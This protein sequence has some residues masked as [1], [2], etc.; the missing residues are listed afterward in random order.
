MEPSASFSFKK[1]P[2]S[3]SSSSSLLLTTIIPVAM[4][5]L[6]S[7][8]LFSTSTHHHHSSTPP[9][10]ILQP[11]P[12]P[13]PHSFI[14]S[15]CDTTLYP[16]LCFNTISSI[17]IN[18][19]HDNHTK[20]RNVLKFYIQ[21]TINRLAITR[22]RMAAMNLKVREKNWV[23]NCLELLDLSQYELQESMNHLSPPYDDPPPYA[24]IKNLLSAAMTNE[25]TCIEGFADLK[26]N[27]PSQ[28]RFGRLFQK[29]LT[30]IMRMISNCLAITNYLETIGSIYT[31][32]DS[33]LMSKGVYR[34][35]VPSWMTAADRRLM[36]TSSRI[37]PPTV[38]VARDG[39]GNFTTIAAA[40]AAAPSRGKGRHVIQIKAGIY[41]ENLVIPRNKANIMLVG[42]GMNSTIITSNKNFVDGYT[43]FT[44]ATLTVV[45]NNFLARDLTI[46]NTSGP[47]KHQAVALRVTS[48]AAFYHCQF[49]SHQD[50]LYA[51]SLSQ[52]YREC[53]IH[54]TID[55]IFG[56]AA[57]IFERCLILVRKP[58]LGQ[59]NV[60]TAQGRLDPNQNTGISLQDCT[61]MAAP[62]FKVKERAN[63][64]TFLGRPWRNYSRTIVMRS[65]LGD[66]IDPQGWCPWNEY[67]NLETV[68][69]I[70]YNNFGP[71]ADTRKRVRWA[72]Y[73]NN[74]R[75]NLEKMGI[76][77]FL[78]G[79]DE[80]LKSTEYLP[81]CSGLYAKYCK[82][83]TTQV[84]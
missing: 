9:P 62:D 75:R 19:H 77:S 60:I 43:T 23:Q 33:R 65:Y 11:P 41:K 39:T 12:S 84:Q 10:L 47:E 32:K 7:S 80:W 36:Q 14:K 69:Y 16:S 27:G 78:H 73:H 28:T 26:L 51:H 21:K 1:S 83:G 82:T 55:F 4:L 48:D 40:V 57:A 34:D 42:D 5:I 46:M 29:S 20:T 61:I 67:S 15:T 3:S 63:F 49:I 59:K 24:A 25:N 66:I 74:S 22:S 13:P 68:E 8:F 64:S 17:P 2:R 52:L 58:I 81:L 6:L 38:V 53:A 70:E 35:H 72:G 37:I 44:S 30:P 54:G 56:N 18:L 76:Q 71:G 45:G 79:A 31:F 50:T